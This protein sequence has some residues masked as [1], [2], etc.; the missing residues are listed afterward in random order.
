MRSAWA[1][2]QLTHW[3]PKHAAAKPHTSLGFKFLRPHA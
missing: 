2:K 3:K 1:S